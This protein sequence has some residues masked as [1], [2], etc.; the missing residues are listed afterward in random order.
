MRYF[1]ICDSGISSKFNTSQLLIRTLYNINGC[2]SKCT[3]W[4]NRVIF[5]P[6]KLYHFN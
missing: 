1:N 4:P 5:S 2:N 3:Y 6:I